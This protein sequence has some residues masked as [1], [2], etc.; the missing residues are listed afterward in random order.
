M[1]DSWLA[2]WR[3]TGLKNRRKDQQMNGF[4]SCIWAHDFY[5]FLW[6]TFLRE[7]LKRHA[8]LYKN[9]STVCLGFS[10]LLEKTCSKMSL[11]RVHFKKKKDQQRTSCKDYL[12]IDMWYF[13]S[14]YLYKSLCCWYS[15]ELPL[16]VSTHNICSYKEVDKSTQAIIWRL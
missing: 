16:L 14:D 9:Y 6:E 12:M 8:P 2:G 1:D 11:I 4:F 13:F 15:F 10:K 5:V 3:M 7:I